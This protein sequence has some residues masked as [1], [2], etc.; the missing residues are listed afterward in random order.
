MGVGS[1]YAANQS[2]SLNL[3][4]AIKPRPSNQTQ[5]PSNYDHAKDMLIM[6]EKC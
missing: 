5:Y 2:D 4:E 6:L 3:C 1:F